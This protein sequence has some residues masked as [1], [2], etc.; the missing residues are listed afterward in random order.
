M[1]FLLSP[2]F[3]ADTKIIS[4]H[5]FVV[6]LKQSMMIIDMWGR[7]RHQFDVMIGPLKYAAFSSIE[8]K[9]LLLKLY[10]KGN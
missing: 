1:L 8:H 6:P 3:V 5:N 4:R 9:L 2:I 7:P 10:C